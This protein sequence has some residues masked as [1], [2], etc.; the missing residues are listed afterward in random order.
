MCGGIQSVVPVTAGINC[1]HAG[2]RAKRRPPTHVGR[3]DRT[4]IATPKRAGMRG[5]NGGAA[6]VGGGA[7]QIAA[8]AIATAGTSSGIAGDVRPVD[9]C[10]PGALACI[11]SPSDGG[12]SHFPHLSA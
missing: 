3:I 8:K 4:S 9:L 10:P 6:P 5:H 11:G 7:S 2:M 1:Y 12:D